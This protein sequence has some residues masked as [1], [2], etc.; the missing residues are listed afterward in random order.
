MGK[1]EQNKTIKVITTDFHLRGWVSLMCLSGSLPESTNS[2]GRQ[3]PGKKNHLQIS[4]L[5]RWVET[6]G[7]HIHF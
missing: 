2:Q 5:Y 4:F 7:K 3:S 6:L 1:C